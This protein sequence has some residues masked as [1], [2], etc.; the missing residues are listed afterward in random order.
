VVNADGSTETKTVTVTV[1]EPTGAYKVTRTS[2]GTKYGLIAQ[3]VQALAETV[4]AF[5]DVVVKIG[6]YFTLD[7]QGYPVKDAQGNNIV[8]KR[9]G[10]DYDAIQ[11]LIAAAEQSLLVKA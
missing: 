7:A 1:S 2:Q 8:N 6:E 9:L 10:L 11:F 5:S 3:D 4:G